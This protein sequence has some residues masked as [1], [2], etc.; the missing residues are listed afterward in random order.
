[1]KKNILI[2]ISSGIKIFFFVIGI[3]SSIVIFYEIYHL[4]NGTPT[5]IC[6]G[7]CQVKNGVM[8]TIYFDNIIYGDR[9]TEENNAWA[10]GILTTALLSFL[11]F[12]GNVE[13]KYSKR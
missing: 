9:L 7:N 6:L 3:I 10:F 13:R 8:A 11:Y 2:K 4:H 12:V 1:M 5:G